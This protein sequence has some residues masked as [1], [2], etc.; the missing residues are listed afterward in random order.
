MVNFKDIEWCKE[1]I[2]EHNYRLK[3]SLRAIEREFSLSNGTV[4]RWCIKH[5]IETLS[6]SDIASICAKDK[7]ARGIGV[8]ENHWAYG[9][10][11]ETSVTHRKHSERM[12]RNNPVHNAVTKVKILNSMCEMQRAKKWPSEIPVINILCKYKIDFIH[13]VVIGNRIV[14]FTIPKAKI[15]IES[16]GRGH[17]DRFA[18]DLVSDRA[19]TK[20]GWKI[21]RIADVR[22]SKNTALDHIVAIII[23]FIPDFNGI[24]PDPTSFGKKRVLIRHPD[25]D[26]D[27]IC[28]SPDDA[29]LD[30]L[31]HGV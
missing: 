19:L 1:F 4:S 31:I 28:N 9:L 20:D 24:S 7:V 5:G 12:K 27:I 2:A 13:Q 14:D 6:R 26:S 29:I 16:D 15:I 17:K 23:K 3:K 11:K 8:G 21:F 10:T 18:S 25:C 30:R 22:V